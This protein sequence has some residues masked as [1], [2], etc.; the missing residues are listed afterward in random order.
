MS[1]FWTV[2]KHTLFRSRWTIL[3]WGVP[4]LLLGVLT[5]PFYD[6][7]AENERSLRSLIQGLKPFLK[8]FIGGDDAENLFTPAGFIAL[9]YFSFIP[10]IMGI[11]G[12]IVGSGLLAVDEERGVLDFVLAHP[13]SRAAVFW[14]RLA[15][16]AAVIGL[17]ILLGWLGLWWGVLMAEELNFPPSQLFLPFLSVIAVAGLFA[18]MG[19]VLSMCMPSRTAAAMTT[20]IFVMASFIITSLARSIPALEVWATI[21][22]LSYF[23]EDAML[24]L[25]IAPLLGLSAVTATFSALAWFGFWKRDIRVSGD[26]GWKLPFSLK[27]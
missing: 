26:S 6:L 16:L 12:A 19:L 11:L 9:R 18:S 2:F 20:G 3:G 7:V 8:S 23:Q 15:G 4:L 17:I 13:A 22:P 27:R 25:E 5:M 14:G 24:G 10:V 21:S 1:S